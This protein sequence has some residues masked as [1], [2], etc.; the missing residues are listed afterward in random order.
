MI[1]NLGEIKAQA[2]NELICGA[3]GVTNLKGGY[4]NEA[5]GDCPFEQ[6]QKSIRP[7]TINLGTGSWE[8][9][10][11]IDKKG[12]DIIQLIIETKKM[13]FHDAVNFVAE[14]SNASID[15]S[16]KPATKL[17]RAETKP[18]LTPQQIEQKLKTLKFLDLAQSH[19]YLKAK[20][21]DPCEGL[22]LGK[23]Y[24]GV[25]SVVV[26]FRDINGVL[27]TGQYVH[28]GPKPFFTGSSTLGAF[29]T[30]G[31]FKDGDNV[32]LAEG[33]ATALTIWMALGKSVPVISFGSANN[34]THT[35]NA[36]KRKYPN[37][38]IIVCLDFG[39]AAF[40]QAIKIDPAQGCKFTWPSFER[41]TNDDPEDKLADFNDLI[42][43]CKQP[44][45]VVRDQLMIEKQ[46]SDLPISKKEMTG[47]VALKA[48]AIPS[49]EQELTSNESSTTTAMPFLINDLE[50]DC[51]K[52]T[53]SNSFEKITVD[54]GFDPEELSIDLFNG[55]IIK[56]GKNT[57]SLNRKILQL[58]KD[59]W[60]NSDQPLMPT[61]IALASD[62]HA[63][64]VHAILSKIENRPIPSAQQVRQRLDKLRSHSAIGNV[65][66]ALNKIKKENIPAQIALD[67]L[68]NE[69]ERNRVTTQVIYNDEHYLAAMMEE[70]AA[71]ENSFI[72][73]E[74]DD[75]NLL[76][77][78]GLRGGKLIV[79]QGKAGAG[80]STFMFQMKDY[81]ASRGT[82]V[83]MVTME[84]S[85]RELKDISITRIEEE[86]KGLLPHENLDNE[87]LHKLVF[88]SYSEKVVK[89][90]FTIEGFKH[91]DMSGHTLKFLTLSEIK[92]KVLYVMQQTGKIPVL[93]IDPF[94][95]CST[96][97]KEM[98]ASEYDKINALIALLK[99][100]AQ[101]LNIPII[102]A[103]D[104]T[105]DHSNN[106]DGEGAGRGT[107]MIQHQADVIITFKESEDNPYEALFG[108]MPPKKEDRDKKDSK[109]D[110]P[111]LN[112]VQK[113]ILDTVD[114]GIF[115]SKYSLKK[116][117]DDEVWLGACVSKNRG[118][119]KRSMLFIYQKD[120]HRF[121]DVP[122]WSKLINW[123]Q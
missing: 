114:H 28:A 46:I 36:L 49:T 34:M 51:I 87:Q 73:T 94:Q 76:L 84:Q 100:L 102:I 35:I 122:L 90:V 59:H 101:I 69:I 67:L 95:R 29:F 104:V 25:D 78:G 106:T 110:K 43:K 103:S 60:N 31:S 24:A 88:Q 15:N 32:Y 81:L 117:S 113:K 30:I 27:Q 92:G 19:P 1:E 45:T 108:I 13:P 85:R 56:D 77:K 115:K 5:R 72:P 14:C 83:V 6:H 109:S 48:D 37:L 42:S 58:I 111:L 96:G 116:D 11:C 12:G 121:K 61:D 8:C 112:R 80:K 9:K 65:E 38:Q 2:N 41:L 89:N 22:Y 20:C 17:P 50:L 44:L 70:E 52:Y 120:K 93:F 105:K 71:E 98:D 21:V 18:K 107:Y 39:D 97:Y 91:V 16:F 3:V 47:A 40:K 64:M 33:L 10:A 54:D 79:L 119:K 86:L 55:N 63:E 62:K 74:F 23:D 66:S 26:P 53:M 99:H 68:S 118:G 82:P 123:E 7:F 4:G 57:I 75:F